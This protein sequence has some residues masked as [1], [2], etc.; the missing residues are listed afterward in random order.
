MFWSSYGE[1]G[2]WISS[3]GMDGTDRKLIVK[4]SYTGTAP[5]DLAVDYE[6]KRIFWFENAART[7]FSCA[8]DGTDI[9]SLNQDVPSSF[10]LDV[11]I[12]TIFWSS[13]QSGIVFSKRKTD[14]RLPVAVSGKSSRVA[15]GIDIQHPSKQRPLPNPCSN[16]TCSHVC[17][18]S[19][20][21]SGF[22]CA[23]PT[24]M[25]L[26]SDNRICQDTT[27]QM[28][29][30]FKSSQQLYYFHHRLIGKDSMVLL[31]TQGQLG[32]IGAIAYDANGTNAVYSR[33]WID[34]SYR[35]AYYYHPNQ[36]YNKGAIYSLNLL[37]QQVKLLFDGVDTEVISMDIDPYTGDV[38]S[39][40]DQS[41]E[42]YS[43]RRLISV[44][45]VTS[46][47]CKRVLMTGLQQ[48]SFITLAPEL[49]LMFIY[50]GT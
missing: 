35:Y 22:S 25:E 48:A 11:V 17:L 15:Y 8:F 16:T 45:K 34:E 33:H 6:L 37:T 29:L 3:A 32:D 20:A 12:D 40:S 19:P 36:Y 46:S 28:S 9:L 50:T 7:F 14:G 4:S 26:A 24:G 1:Q 2:I 39:I 44:T 5:T 21:S 18:L 49:S 38:Y 30:L 41:S 27:S 13:P 10:A 47:G 43:E 42:G 31:P 23:C